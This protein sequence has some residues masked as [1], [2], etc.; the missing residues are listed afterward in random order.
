MGPRGEAPR[1]RSRA[2]DASRRR[3]AVRASSRMAAL[4]RARGRRRR[5]TAWA[6]PTTGSRRPRAQPRGDAM[7]EAKEANADRSSS[8]DAGP[9][10]SSAGVLRGVVRTLP[11]RAPSP[12]LRTVTHR[13]DPTRDEPVQTHAGTLG[14]V[15]PLVVRR[16]ARVSLTRAR[17]IRERAPAVRPPD[18]RGVAARARQPRTRRRRIVRTMS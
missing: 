3:R 1:A 10:L 12:D 2:S 8:R 15:S 7:A 11:V 13:R 6:P 9:R 16:R 14:R 5:Y 17:G 4:Q 18:A